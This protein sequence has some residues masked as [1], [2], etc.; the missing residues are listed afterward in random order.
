MI[1]A[2]YD[3]DIKKYIKCDIEK[4]KRELT[5]SLIVLITETCRTDPPFHLTASH[6]PRIYSFNSIYKFC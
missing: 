6:V 2:V 5:S 4:G 3:I 1:I